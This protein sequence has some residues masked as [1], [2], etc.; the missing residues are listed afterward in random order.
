M[1]EQK[2]AIG[3]TV[4]G[5]KETLLAIIPRADGILISKMYFE[6]EIKDLP[7][8]YNKPEIV[9]AELTMAKAL[10]N[11]MVNPFEPAAYKDEYQVKLRELLETKIAGK[12]IVASKDEA[13]SNIISLMD[14]L[15]ASIDQ[16]KTAQEPA[17]KAPRK[18]TPKG[19]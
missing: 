18:K 16:N 7:K 12:D 3:K 11:S 19:A 2:I 15:K 10:I 1:S 8:S 9:E 13:P 5:T 4:M 17:T 6:D 14:A